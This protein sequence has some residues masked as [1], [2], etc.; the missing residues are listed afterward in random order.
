MGDQTTI[1]GELWR[2][3]VLASAP[4]ETCG[5]TGKVESRALRA[6]LYAGPTK[7]DC[8]ACGGASVNVKAVAARY[9]DGPET[10]D[11]TCRSPLTEAALE[12]YTHQRPGAEQL[13]VCVDAQAESIP[14]DC[15]QCAALERLVS[16]LAAHGRAKAAALA[17][18]GDWQDE[19]VEANRLRRAEGAALGLLEGSG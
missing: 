14:C 5:G 15:P 1:D 6:A 19:Y 18:T 9:S 7:V 10:S 2:D 12:A 17:G 8:P 13:I 4:C 16:C 11:D 3:C